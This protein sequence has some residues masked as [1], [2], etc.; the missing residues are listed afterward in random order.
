M[1][2]TIQVPIK[3]GAQERTA[4]LTYTANTTSFDV[5]KVEVLGA[6]V[7]TPYWLFDAVLCDVEEEGPI[8]DMLRADWKEPDVQN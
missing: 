2:R 8:L 5:L 1:Q 4:E 3:V 6:D 7:G